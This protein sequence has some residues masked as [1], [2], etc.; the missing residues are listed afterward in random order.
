MYF[1]GMQRTSTLDYPDKLCAVLFT[2]GCNF[3]CPFCHNAELIAKVPEEHQIPQRD[4]IDMLRERKR[5]VNAVSITGGEPTMQPGLLDFIKKIKED[6]FFVK[7][8]TNGTNPD[9]LEKLL[10]HLDFIAMDIKAPLNEDDYHLAVNARPNID[11][12][13]RSMELIMNSGIEYEFRTTVVPD[14]LPMEKMHELGKSVK[15][16][17]KIAI[18]QF[19]REHVFDESFKEKAIYDP[20]EINDIKLI[21]EEYVDNVEIRGI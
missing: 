9:Y 1:A 5:L 11:Y 4:V 21:L 12:I 6:G 14:L 17:K 13:K 8:D 15:G 19:Q 16:A 7:I 10:P 3:R 2:D 18:Q 20:D